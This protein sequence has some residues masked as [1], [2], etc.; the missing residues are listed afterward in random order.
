MGT[1]LRDALR[2]AC[3]L[4]ARLAIVRDGRTSGPVRSRRS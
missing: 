1:I 2:R 4:E 3:S